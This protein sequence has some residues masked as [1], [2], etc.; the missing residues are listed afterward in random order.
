MLLLSCARFT[1]EGQA[2]RGGQVETI[3]P[4]AQDLDR[5]L[6]GSQG[7]LLWLGAISPSRV[8]AE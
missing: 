6:E 3:V 4:W 2:G 1:G 8:V 5:P 7:R